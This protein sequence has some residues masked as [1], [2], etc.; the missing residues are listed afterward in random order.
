MPAAAMQ[1][2]YLSHQVSG[3]P[4]SSPNRPIQDSLGR[5]FIHSDPDAPCTLVPISVS[6]QHEGLGQPRWMLSTIDRT[7]AAS[8]KEE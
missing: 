4:R 1:C 7:A 2:C 3:S 5:L 8:S 6:N